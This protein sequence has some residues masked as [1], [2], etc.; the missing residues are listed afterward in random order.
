[1]TIVKCG[2]SYWIYLP[3]TKENIDNNEYPQICLPYSLYK[4]LPEFTQKSL[5]RISKNTKKRLEK[6]NKDAKYAY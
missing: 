2:D 4:D 1:M 5:E 3:R 6:E